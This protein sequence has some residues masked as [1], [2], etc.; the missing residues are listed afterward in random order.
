MKTIEVKRQEPVEQ[1]PATSFIIELQPAELKLFH[2][3]VGICSGNT[4]S[5][6]GLVLHSHD[7]YQDLSLLLNASGHSTITYAKVSAALKNR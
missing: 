4:I 3:L 2:A 5:N 7:L 1:P 6:L